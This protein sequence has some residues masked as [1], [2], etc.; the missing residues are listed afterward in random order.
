M[1]VANIVSNNKINVSED[2]NVVKSMDEI[3][4]GLPTLII[5]F[6]Y[7][8]KHFPDF[9]ILDREI[10]KDLYWTFKKTER[11]DKHEEDLI[12]FMVNSYN[13]LLQDISYVF[14]DP[15]QYSNKTMLKILR[16]LNKIKNLVSVQNDEM[17]YIYGEKIIFGVDLRLLEYMG[18]KKDRI[19]TLIKSNCVEFLEKNQILI[20]YK[21]YVEDLDIP[22]KY[23]PYLLSIKNE[24]NDTTSNIYISREG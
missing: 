14:I 17:I 23:I 12:W 16:K 7:V 20:E 10:S 1:I 22:V 15:I 21:K 5:G 6:D 8:N 19:K 11:R 24:Q 3:I 2:F 4:H 18:Y 9:N 13:F